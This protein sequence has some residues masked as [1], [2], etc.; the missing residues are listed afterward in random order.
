MYIIDTLFSSVLHSS[1]ENSNVIKDIAH[2]FITRPDK[3]LDEA[4]EAALD[5][6]K[7]QPVSLYRRYAKPDGVEGKA[8]EVDP[9]AKR[10]R[11]ST[12]EGCNTVT[13]QLGVG[14]ALEK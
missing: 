14:E 11:N 7:F 3:G 4:L 13:P 9:P 2:C 1:F 12:D 8:G 5:T 6:A 10:Y